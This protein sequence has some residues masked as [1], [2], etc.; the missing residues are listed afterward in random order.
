MR[1]AKDKAELS[2][3]PAVFS[4]GEDRFMAEWR[5]APLR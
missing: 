2:R 3:L 5:K 1:Q 4:T